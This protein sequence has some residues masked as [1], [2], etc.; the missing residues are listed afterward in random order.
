MADSEI[1]P[2]E[3]NLIRTETKGVEKKSTYNKNLQLSE[4]KLSDIDDIS[5]GD[6]LKVTNKVENTKLSTYGR[7]EPR[8]EKTHRKGMDDGEVALGQTGR[9]A[10]CAIAGEDSVKVSRVG[11]SEVS[12]LRQYLNR[13]I[14][15][16]PALCRARKAISTDAG[17]RV[18]RLREDVKQTIGIEWGDHI[19]LQ[20]SEGR[21][22]GIKALP[23]TDHQREIVGDRQDSDDYRSSIEETELSEHIDQSGQHLPKIHIAQATRQALGIN[24]EQQNNGVHQP[25]RIHR[26]TRYVAYRIMHDLTTPFLLALIAALIGLDFPPKVVMGLIA[27]GFGV[28]TLSTYLQSRQVLR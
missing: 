27:M 19:I 28:L 13:F 15:V 12:V 10:I 8:T 11:F 3:F 23:L 4:N 21:V 14:G 1:L 18:C 2:E 26:D 6:F 5:E 25:V 22:R 20:S 24:N 17:Y 9:D 16:R 7:V